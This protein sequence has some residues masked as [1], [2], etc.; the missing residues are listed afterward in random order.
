M[1]LDLDMQPTK[2]KMNVANDEGNFVKNNWGG[3]LIRW[4]LQFVGQMVY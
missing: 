2:M 4:A 3:T 1:H